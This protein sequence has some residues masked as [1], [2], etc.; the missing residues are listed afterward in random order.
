MFPFL[1]SGHYF[2]TAKKKNSGQIIWDGGSNIIQSKNTVAILI[3]ETALKNVN[4]ST[5]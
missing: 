4:S 1:E 3:E 2:G 5:F